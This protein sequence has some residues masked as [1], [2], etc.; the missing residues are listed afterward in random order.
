MLGRI[1][2]IYNVKRRRSG[3]HKRS[4]ESRT[5]GEARPELV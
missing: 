2:E 1:E 3:G 5:E 4:E